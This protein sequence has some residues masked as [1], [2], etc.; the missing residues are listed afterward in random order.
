M[1]QRLACKSRAQVLCHGVRD[2]LRSCSLQFPRRVMNFP[3]QNRPIAPLCIQAISFRQ[4][5]VEG[6]ALRAK[7]LS[8]A[9]VASLKSLAPASPI[10]SLRKIDD[11]LP[12]LLKCHPGSKVR[13]VKPCPRHCHCDAIR[14]IQTEKPNSP[15]SSCLHVRSHVQFRKRRKPRHG[16]RPSQTH[17]GHAKRHNPNPRL[18]VERI[19]LQLAR[20]QR[21]QRLHGNRPVREQQVLPVL[22]HHPRTRGQL[23]RPVLHKFQRR[24]HLYSPLMSVFLANITVARFRESNPVDSNRTKFSS[25]GDSTCNAKLPPSGKAI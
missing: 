22:R 8:L 24:M 20:H 13:Q 18:P 19:Q 25:N 14:R 11:L 15:L 2:N 16:R 21:T 5:M 7:R 3:A 10:R 6:P 12:T 1:Q 9:S 4:E 17:C 23:P